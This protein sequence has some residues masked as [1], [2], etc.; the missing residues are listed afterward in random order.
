MKKQVLSFVLIA[1]ALIGFANV[2]FAQG[3][4]TGTVIDQESGAPLSN[5]AIQI[6]GTTSG[7]VA[8][9]DGY[10]EI[11]VSG[12]ATLIISYLGYGEK[13]VTVSVSNNSTKNLGKIRMQPKS[14]G[15]GGVN[16]IADR[17][18]ERETPVAISNVDA[19]QIELQLGSRDIPLIMNNTPGVY[20]TA[21]GGGAGDSRIN[22]RGFD[23]RNVAVMINGVPVNDMEN[24]W[25]YW[26]NWDG[27]ADATS[28]IQMQRGLSAV[29]LATP[30]IGGTMNIITTPAEQK[31]GVVGRFEA[32][33][34]GFMKTSMTGHSGLINNKL[35]VS[36][37]VAK[38]AGNGVIDGTW[39]ETWSYYLGLSYS[40]NE[41]HR[42]EAYIVGA[43]QRHGQNLY[44]QNVAAYDT[45][46]AKEI[47]ADSAAKY[48]YSNPSSS[49]RLY[50]QNWS[51]VSDSY[52]GQQNWNGKTK[53][54]YDNSFI[55]ERENFYHKPL[56]NLNW[57][58]QW[59]KNLSQFTTV[60]YSGGTGGGTGTI[61]KIKW[62]YSDE[63]SRII[64][65][66]ATIANNANDTAFGILRNSR[67]NQH[68]F[69]GIS[70]IKYKINDNL[71]IQTG[72]DARYAKI[73][74]YREVRDLLG[75]NFYIDQ[76][77]AFDSPSEYNKVLGDRIAYNFTNTVNW[78]GAF[79]QGEYSTEKI[80]IYGT[81]GF[82]TIKYNYTNHFKKNDEGSGE[83]TAESGWLSGSQIKGGM[84]YRPNE[85]LSVFGNIGF[86]SKAPIFDNVIN[87]RNGTVTAD[88]KNEKF[89]A[90]EAGA[91]YTTKNKMLDVKANYYY[92]TWKDRAMSVRT[93][94]PDGS[95]GN[96]FLSGMNQTHSGFELEAK[97]RIIKQ[98]G[99][100]AIGSFGNWEYTNDVSGE[101]KNYNP[102]TTI[103]Y[104]YYVK[105]LKV[106]DAPQTQFAFWLDLYPVKGL[107]MQFIYRY[108]T[109]YYANWDPFSRTDET[110]RAQ[111]WEVPSY[112][113]L[114]FHVSYNIP[115]KGRVGL[116]VFGHVFNAFNKMYISDAVDNSRYNGYYGATG[117]LSHTANSAEV[118]IGLPRTFN[119][120][121]KVSFQ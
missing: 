108:N 11:E 95:E 5:V 79:I 80:S 118:F 84:S 35:A 64:D 47:G 42:L 48:K 17:A 45:D 62:N 109:N 93:T 101:Y 10:F 37:S 8:D 44:K 83:L 20:A 63:P 57:Y 15:I 99:I 30:S 49:G 104:N 106:G 26:S 40:L 73:E 120:G 25:V 68:T 23:Q 86:V 19:K 94:N 59:T 13:K 55:N 52:T 41:K 78:V 6:E 43:S 12:S 69:G 33:S 28:S 50:N 110:D 27:V 117:N 113:L 87:D 77:S 96:V 4:V 32:G 121:I 92:T 115:L 9:L 54:R 71:K 114:D 24:G 76:S 111:V 98:V 21:Q 81:Y 82:S 112:G 51:P 22:V 36:A 66:D 88:P 70:K 56:A 61:G 102:D 90:Y 85:Q 105:G 65:Y 2:S 67:N 46:Y 75:G 116:Q 31:A 91:L 72:I 16:I 53:D 89:Q 119:V 100:G 103:K 58:A 7:V 107:Q 74:H 14:M 39:G 1:I 60:Y 97:Y 3:T 38:K 29:N 34:G 18:K